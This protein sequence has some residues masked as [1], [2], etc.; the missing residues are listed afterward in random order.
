MLKN[1]A[2]CIS[3]LAFFT[4]LG[5]P[6]FTLF[7]TFTTFQGREPGIPAG[8]TA[9]PRQS[10]QS[11]PLWAKPG[12]PLRDTIVTPVT[13]FTGLVLPPYLD[14]LRADA[15]FWIALLPIAIE[16]PHQ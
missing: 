13:A 3:A 9:L 2:L 11:R 1:I 6:L 15:D 16:R 7:T 5:S 14:A 12:I 8:G 10:R 4:V